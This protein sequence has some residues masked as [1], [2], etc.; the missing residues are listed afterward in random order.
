MPDYQPSEEAVE[1]HA[2]AIFDGMP[3][4]G[5]W[6]TAGPESK[7]FYRDL[8]RKALTAAVPIE[9]ERE[10]ERLLDTDGPLFLTLREAIA[11]ELEAGGFQDEEG[12]SLYADHPSCGWLGREVEKRIRAAF[13]DPDHEEGS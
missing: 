3:G 9:L 12:E 13:K 1:R 5:F 6:E 4:F 10:R 8:S 11:E 7:A 2:Q